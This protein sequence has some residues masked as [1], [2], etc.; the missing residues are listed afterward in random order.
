NLRLNGLTI[1][2]GRGASGGGLS[3][4]GSL[5]LIQCRVTANGSD[6]DGGGI[7]NDATGRLT[8]DS[9]QVTNNRVVSSSMVAS[10]GG[11][12][13][14]GALRLTSSMV[15]NNLVRSTADAAIGAGI[16]V[17]LGGTVT[18]NTSQV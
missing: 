15:N 10:G 9:T 1:T 7:A 14:A 12:E 5:T 6:S 17:A 16:D 13:D 18:L 8:L 4:S 2:G 11:I 3:N